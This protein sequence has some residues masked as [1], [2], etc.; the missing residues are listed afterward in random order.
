M[1]VTTRTVECFVLNKMLRLTLIVMF[2][3]TELNEQ[4]GC[5][6][7]SLLAGSHSFPALEVFYVSSCVSLATVSSGFPQT[8]RTYPTEVRKSKLDKLNF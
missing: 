4:S 5:R 6:M 7:T 1:I 3:L 8:T 2:L